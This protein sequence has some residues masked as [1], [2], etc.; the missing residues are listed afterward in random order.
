MVANQNKQQRRIC[1]HSHINF[2]MD[3]QVMKDKK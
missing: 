3:T 2:Y 1:K